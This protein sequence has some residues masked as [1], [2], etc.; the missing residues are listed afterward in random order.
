MLGEDFWR[1]KIGDPRQ[2][3]K[4]PRF[5]AR[6][7]GGGAEVEEPVWKTEKQQIQTRRGQNV[8]KSRQERISRRG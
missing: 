7:A 1:E 3:R 8:G 6:R 4:M 5:G 2:S